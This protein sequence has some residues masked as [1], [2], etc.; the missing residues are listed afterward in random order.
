MSRFLPL[1]P[2]VAAV[3]A[4]MP[5][6]AATNSDDYCVLDFGAKADGKTDATSAFQKA[7]ETASKAGGGTVYAP[8]GIYF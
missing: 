3:G 8:R 4:L 1:L 6:L 7:M 5:A 2:L